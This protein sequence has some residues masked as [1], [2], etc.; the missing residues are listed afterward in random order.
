MLLGGISEKSL[1]RYLQA[2]KILPEELPRRGNIFVAP[3]KRSA[4]RGK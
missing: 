4:T 2:K 1:A 3:G